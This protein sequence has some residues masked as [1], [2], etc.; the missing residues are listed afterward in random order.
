MHGEIDVIDLSTLSKRRKW[1]QE[2]NGETTDALAKARQYTHKDSE[3]GL[4]RRPASTAI[5]VWNTVTGIWT[6]A[7]EWE[8]EA[9]TGRVPTASLVLR[10]SSEG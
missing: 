9:V 1:L 10:G 5:N 8:Q 4:L 2:I 3:V 6:S 7:D